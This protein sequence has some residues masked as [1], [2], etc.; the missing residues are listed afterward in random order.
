MK[1]KIKSI[2]IYHPAIAESFKKCDLIDWFN[3]EYEFGEGERWA[4]RCSEDQNSSQGR[5][6]PHGSYYSEATCGRLACSTN[7]K[8]FASCG[9]RTVFSYQIWM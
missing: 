5:S 2:C 9:Q 6:R 3:P 4:Q 1:A 8:V 7:L